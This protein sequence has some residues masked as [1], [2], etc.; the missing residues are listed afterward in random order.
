[1]QVL[2]LG[3]EIDDF[4]LVKKYQ[5]YTREE[6]ESLP[7]IEIKELSLQIFEIQQ[8]VDWNRV[9]E[10]RFS[11]Q[12]ENEVVVELPKLPVQPKPFKSW[13]ECWAHY[14]T[15]VGKAEY[16]PKDHNIE[17]LVPCK[18]QPDWVSPQNPNIFLEYKGVIQ[19]ADDAR[20]YRLV[21]EQTGKTI[22][23]VF[24]CRN[25]EL[26]FQ[27]PRKDGTRQT[28]EEWCNKHGFDYT[29]GD[30]YN[31]FIRNERYRFLLANA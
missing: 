7:L 24:Q 9:N 16:E 2:K 23:F 27:K 28:Q 17:Y 13:Y 14:F 10:I 26:P 1:M 6:I 4:D 31:D 8:A 3:I 25:I 30:E 12:I 15:I 18:Y 21:R 22:I 11:K 5:N 19:S 29:Y 20:K